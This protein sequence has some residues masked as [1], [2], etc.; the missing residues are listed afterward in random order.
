MMPNE[1]K[2]NNYTNPFNFVLNSN[3]QTKKKIIRLI[4]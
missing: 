2:I 3:N 1:E 4:I